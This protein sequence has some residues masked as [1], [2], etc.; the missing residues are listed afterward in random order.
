MPPIN[1]GQSEKSA[2]EDPLI[3]SGNSKEI[4]RSQS[5]Q[6]NYGY[7]SRYGAAIVQDTVEDPTIEVSGA[8]KDDRLENW[9]VAVNLIKGSIGTG[10]LGLP[11]AIKHAGLALG[12]AVLSLMGLLSLHN[13]HLLVICSRAM[14]K[15]NH[16]SQRMDYGE[17]TNLVFSHY[18]KK[19][20]NAASMLVNFFLCLVQLGFCC[21]YVLFVADNLYRIS[22]Q[23]LSVKIW[24]AIS[25]PA[26]LGFSFID[27]LTFISYISIIANFFALFGL[28]GVLYNVIPLASNPTKLPLFNSFSTFALFFGQSV[29]AFEG[30]GVILPVE[31]KAKKP[32]DFVFVM[33]CSIIFVVIL[34]IAVGLFGYLAYPDSI[35][36]SVTLNLSETG[37]HIAVQSVYALA[38]FCTYFIQFYVPMTIMIPSVRRFSPF[39]FVKV[40]DVFFRTVCVCVTFGVAVGVPQLGNSIALVGSLAGSAVLFVFPSLLHL[41]VIWD[42]RHRFVTKLNIAKNIFIMVIGTIGAIVGTYEA[43]NAIINDRNISPA[44]HRPDGLTFGMTT[45]RTTLDYV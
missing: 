23:S 3:I 7:D 37:F 24:A 40:A 5:Y 29:F 33:Y 43:V 16:V 13:M 10:I 25:L 31:K 45:N 44:K 15:R 42:D 26:F 21:V 2:E 22:G 19:W 12:P 9:Q 38:I 35:K 8:P 27:H 20:K 41:L 32:K 11:L 6:G 17:L 30:I 28:F 1:A 34:Y 39:K 36:G 4:S 14:A 18:C